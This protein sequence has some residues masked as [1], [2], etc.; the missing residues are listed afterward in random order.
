MAV[1][2]SYL[3]DVFGYPPDNLLPITTEEIRKSM[4]VV[5]FVPCEPVFEEGLDLFKISPTWDQYTDLLHENG[6][7]SPNKNSIKLA[8]LAD[9]FPTD[10]FTNEYGENFLQGLTDIASEGAASIAQMFGAKNATG[11]YKNIKGNLQMSEGATSKM[12]GA[13]MEKVEDMTRGAMEALNNAGSIGQTLGRSANLLNNLMAGSRV[14][15]PMVWKSSAYQPS[16]SF[17][18]RLYNPNP[19]DINSTKKYIVG[20]IVAMLLLGVP[21][22]NG[23]STYTW[24]FLHKIKC[25][26][27]FNLDPGFISNITV[28]KGGDQ[29]QIS[30]Q[31][32]MGIVDIRIDVGSLYS[33]ILAGS[34]NLSSRRPTVEKFA[35]AM[36]GE[37]AP[38][39]KTRV[40]L[41]AKYYSNSS[42]SNDNSAYIKKLIQPPSFVNQGRDLLRKVSPK[43]SAKVENVIDE[44]DTAT[45]DAIDAVDEVIDEGMAV[46]N[47]VENTVD[48]VSRDSIDKYNQ[49]RSLLS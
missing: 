29:Q 5:E 4:P 22:S 44:I 32:R 49:L 23:S 48:R 41:N 10:S 19:R 43:I 47:Q 35:T 1:N 40:D 3:L 2:P 42:F 33:S 46:Y 11:V 12:V 25:P 6:F 36:L 9:N 18:V 7:T 38:E 24:P 8:F 26:G 16:Y 14:D 17:T 15:F 34:P 27:I 45:Q 21:R 39:V 30:F 13:G 20:P 31:Q 28:V 37:K